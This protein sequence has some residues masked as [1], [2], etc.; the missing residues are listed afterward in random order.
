MK[1]SGSRLRFHH[2][3]QCQRD[4]AG[5]IRSYLRAIWLARLVGRHAGHRA[6]SRI[7]S[8]NDPTSIDLHAQFLQDLGVSNGNTEQRLG[9]TRGRAT[10]LLPLL[11]RPG[12]HTKE[13]RKGL[14]RQAHPCASLG[15]FR[16]R[17][18]RG[19]R[20]LAA[21]HLL[22]GFK[23]ILLELFD[24][25]GHLRLLVSTLPGRPW[26]DCRTWL[27]CRRSR[28]KWFQCSR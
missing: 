17:D 23:Q 27:F 20:G 22:D 28:A 24:L 8:W 3:A 6:A 1:Y 16:Q 15:C 4:G 19:A 13:V 7:E 9:S 5:A 2:S 18:T 10:P 21:F 11:Q 14:L 25:R 26:G 12:G